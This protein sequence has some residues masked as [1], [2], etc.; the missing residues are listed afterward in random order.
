MICFHIRKLLTT[1]LSF[2]WSLRM[3]ALKTLNAAMALRGAETGSFTTVDL[4]TCDPLTGDTV[5]YKYGAA[6]SY[7]KKGGSVR[8][9][10]G[11]SLPVGL[12]GNPAA[13][14]VTCVRLEEGGS[15]VMISDGVADPGRDEWLMD[16]LAG[17]EGEDPQ[18]LAGLVLAESV[19]REKLQDDCGIQV[20][21]R[22]VSRE[23]MV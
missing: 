11:V 3:A 9:V 18:A 2:A 15:L 20:L 5:F 22:P 8:R 17:W 1:T 19:R 13:P 16:L 21:Y 14:D 7:L 4:C 23:K 6:P 10:T 12:R